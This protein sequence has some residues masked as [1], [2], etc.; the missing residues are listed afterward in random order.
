MNATLRLYFGHSIK[1]VFHNHWNLT[2]ILSQEGSHLILHVQWSLSD[3]TQSSSAQGHLMTADSVQTSSHLKTKA[4]LLRKWFLPVEVLQLHKWVTSCQPFQNPMLTYL[5]SK[6][7]A[8]LSR[9]LSC[10]TL[11]LPNK[12]SN[13]QYYYASISFKCSVCM[14]TNY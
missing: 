7:T 3:M 2:K 6:H 11:L 12:Q 5:G 4:L 14:F 13:W 8:V 9:A 10:I 1:K